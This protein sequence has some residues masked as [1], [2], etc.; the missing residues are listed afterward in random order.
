MLYLV[1]DHSGSHSE[2]WVLKVGSRQFQND[3]WGTVVS[4]TYTYGPGEYPITLQHVDSN[5][6]CPDHD[7]TAFVSP[8]GGDASVTIEDPQSKNYHILTTTF[9]N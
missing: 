6:A 5:L 8:V 9:S 3:V 1:G 7:Y 2:R 4:T